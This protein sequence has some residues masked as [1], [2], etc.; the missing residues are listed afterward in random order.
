[1]SRFSVG[2]AVATV[3]LATAGCAGRS[4]PPSGA[5][6]VEPA[7]TSCDDAGPVPSGLAP[8]AGDTTATLP[9]LD[10]SFQPVAAVVCSSAPQ[11]RSD[12]GTDLTATESRAGDVTALVA[13]LRLPDE[14]LTDDLCTME[15]YLPPFFVLLDEQGRWVRPGLPHDSCGKVRIEVR[16]ALRALRLTPLSSRP[17]REIESSEAAAA[18]CTQQWADMVAATAS[19]VRTSEPAVIPPGFDGPV[20]V[21]VC[22]YRVPPDQQGTGKPAGEFVSGRHLSDD[23][24]AA[25][26]QAIESAAPVTPCTTPANRFAVLHLATGEVYAELDGCRRLLASAADGDQTLRRAAPALLAQLTAG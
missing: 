21:R 18:G 20:Q 1:M 23:Q 14:P 9:R 7:W 5:L 26:R 3:V 13:A 4:S 12:G 8:E 15:L 25:A 22:L 19:T 11:G 10:D 17:I 24:W 16:D 2:L 6:R